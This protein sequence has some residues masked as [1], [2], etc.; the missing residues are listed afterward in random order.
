M[1]VT[2]E[3]PPGWL[4]DQPIFVADPNAA[5][6]DEWDEE[7]DGV[8]EPPL[9]ANPLCKTAVGCGF[10]LTFHPIVL[11]SFLVR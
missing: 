3:A 8:W 11:F 6:P 9:I 2:T 7:D 1:K 5:P 10:T 4:P